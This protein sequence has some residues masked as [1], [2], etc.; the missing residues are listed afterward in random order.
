MEIPRLPF[1]LISSIILEA[2]TTQHQENLDA[3]EQN[4]AQV[5]TSLES[6]VNKVLFETHQDEYEDWEEF[7]IACEDGEDEDLV[8]IPAYYELF[9]GNWRTELNM[10]GGGAGGGGVHLWDL[11][12]RRAEMLGLRPQKATEFIPTF[13]VAKS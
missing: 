7:M 13:Q 11:E 8:G 2:T 12:S 6:S 5:N 3:W 4:I 10:L 9:E 1:D